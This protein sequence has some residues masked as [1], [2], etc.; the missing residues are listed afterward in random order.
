MNQLLFINL[1]LQW[2]QYFEIVNPSI[3]LTFSLFLNSNILL[4]FKN[5]N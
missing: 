1:Y 3:C 5:L 2:F 4:I